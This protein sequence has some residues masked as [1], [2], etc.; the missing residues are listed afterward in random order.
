MK[1]TDA[2]A[3]FKTRA[4][5]ARALKINYASVAGWGEEVPAL[6]QLQLEALTHGALRAAEKHK[7]SVSE[8]V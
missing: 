1:T 2:I 3:H 8:A 5:L 6:R 4:N 7:L